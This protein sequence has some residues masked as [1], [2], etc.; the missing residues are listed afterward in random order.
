MRLS[1]LT[2]HEKHVLKQYLQDENR[3]LH[4]APSGGTIHTLV[5]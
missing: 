4:W 3:T 2:P 1:D 5:F